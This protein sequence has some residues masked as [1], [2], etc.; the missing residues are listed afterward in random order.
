MASDVHGVSEPGITPPLTAASRLPGSRELLVDC[1]EL[2]L[3]L[4]DR[5]LAVS[6]GAPCE[7][8]VVEELLPNGI[9]ICISICTCIFMY[10]Y[11]YFYMCLDI[12]MYLYMNSV[13]VS[14]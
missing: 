3:A 5:V 6:H 11:L 14:L 12:C 8:L 13:Y 4:A 10:L 1:L 9:S 2:S 7:A